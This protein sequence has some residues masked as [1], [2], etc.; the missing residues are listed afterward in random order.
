VSHP[1]DVVQLIEA[2][3]ETVGASSEASKVSRV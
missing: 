3:A 1:N 2:A